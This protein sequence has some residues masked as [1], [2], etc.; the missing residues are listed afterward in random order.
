M[1]CRLVGSGRR[2]SSARDLAVAGALVLVERSNCRGV[3]GRAG[4]R[5]ALALAAR[6]WLTVKRLPK[7][8]PELNDIEH[9]WRDL[10][11]HVLAHQIFRAPHAPN[12]AVSKLRAERRPQPCANLRLAA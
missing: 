1:C 10:K 6:P 3:F 11:R 5:L 7:Y 8:G 9:V 4:Q 12:A 2:G